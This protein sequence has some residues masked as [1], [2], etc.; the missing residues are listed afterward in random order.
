MKR[1]NFLSNSSS[2]LAGAALI[3]NSK[4]WAGANERVRLAMIG[5][6]WRGGQLLPV[7]AKNPEVKVVTLCDPDERRMTEWNGKLEEI[8]GEKAKLTPDMREIM[9]DQEIDAVLISTPNHWH[10]LAAIW[11]SQ[12]GKHTYVEKPVC[13]AI[14]EGQKMVEAVRKYNRISQGGPQRRSHN[15][16]RNAIE[17]LHNGVIGDVYMAKALVLVP[18]ESLGFKP[19]Q[20]PPPWLH[21]DLWKGPGPDVGYHENLVHY[22][23]HWFWH[24]GNGEMANNGIHQIDVCRWGLNKKLPVK[25]QSGGGRFGY[26][27]QGETPNVQHASF[28]YDDGTI[29][30]A[31]T[32]GL[33][34]NSE[35]DI[36]SSGVLFY[37][38]KGYMVIDNRNARIY[39]GRN[40]EPEII[41]GRGNDAMHFQN[42]ING[43]RTGK[44][45]TLHAEIEEIF[46]STCL[47]LLA[48][49]SYRLKQEVTFDPKQMVL[50][51]DEKVNALLTRTYRKPFVLPEEV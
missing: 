43:I 27:D 33:P 46:L 3:G 47:P 4:S 21:W 16:Y 12:N 42:F 8:T 31:E 7:A 18:R 20:E 6:G 50:I 36:E 51:G 1:R 28:E 19:V 35:G 15:L 49:I 10:A 37:G 5:M 30:K 17:K 44:P 38:S 32:R 25:I 29:L 9:E 14:R 26:Q 13:Y 45:E 40:K 39:Q 22:N 48:N 2:I 34:T 23:W 11:A 24:F 41:E